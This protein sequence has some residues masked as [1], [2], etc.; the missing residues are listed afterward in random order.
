MSTGICEKCKT[1]IG[2]RLCP[3][4][5]RPRVMRGCFCQWEALARVSF[6]HWRDSGSDLV[7]ADVD[8]VTAEL[9]WRDTV[10]RLL[11]DIALVLGDLVTEQH[12]VND[13]IRGF[14]RHERES[15][16]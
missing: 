12:K 4:Y 1:P 10:Q 5:P 8:P 14:A 11:E 3:T 2:P 13:A 15:A 16:R 9:I 7:T 6:E